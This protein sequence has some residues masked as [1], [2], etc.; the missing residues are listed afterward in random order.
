MNLIPLP[1]TIS[2]GGGNPHRTDEKRAEPTAGYG[3]LY[4]AGQKAICTK[5]GC[6]KRCALSLG[7]FYPLGVSLG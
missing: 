5:A 2:G 1:V 4:R 7:D 6:C 3:M